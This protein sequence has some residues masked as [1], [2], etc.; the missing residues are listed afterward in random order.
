MNVIKAFYY[1]KAARF[2]SEIAHLMTQGA[3]KFRSVLGKDR[4]LAIFD[5]AD[6]I[7]EKAKANIKLSEEYIR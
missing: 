4:V 7:T 2:H 6:A 5:K 3:I 1:S